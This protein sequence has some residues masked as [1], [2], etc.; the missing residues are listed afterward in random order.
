MRAIPESLYE[1]FK[2]QQGVEPFFVIAIN[3]N[4]EEEIKYSTKEFDDIYGYVSQFS[5]FE[6]VSHAEGL[7]AVSSIAIK[8]ND[9]FGH[10]KEKIDTV[11]LFDKTTVTLYLTVDGV[12]LFDLFEGIIE[13]SAE[14]EGHIWSIDVSSVALDDEVGYTPSIDD[15]AEDHPLRGYYERHLKTEGWPT[16]FND[17]TKYNAVLIADP[18]VSEVQ[19]VTFEQVEGKFITPLDQVDDYDLDTEYHICLVGKEKGPSI[20]HGMGTFRSDKTVEITYP[21]S[22]IWYRDILCQQVTEQ[23]PI[24]P[25]TGQSPR[26]RLRISVGEYSFLD[27]FGVPYITKVTTGPDGDPVTGAWLQLMTARITYS[28]FSGS[29]LISKVLTCNC[30]K[31]EYDICTFDVA[32]LVE[33][34]RNIEIAEAG[35]GLDIIFNIPKETK[36]YIMGDVRRYVV[37]LKTGASTVDIGFEDD[38]RFTTI[39]TDLYEVKTDQLFDHPPCTYVEIPSH[40]IPMWESVKTLLARVTNTLTT[41]QLVIAHLTGKT[42]TDPN[43]KTVNFTYTS[44]EDLKSIIPEIA[45]QSNKGVRRSRAGG[46]DVYELIDLTNL[47]PPVFAFTDHNILRDSISYGYSTEESLKTVFSADF[48]GRD[49]LEDVRTIKYKKNVDKYGEKLLDVDMYI[50]KEYDDADAAFKWWRDKLSRVYY[51]IKFTGFLDAFGL[52][53]WDRVS[54]DFGD[55]RFYDPA[56]GSP[57]NLTHTAT[58]I[59]WRSEGTVKAVRP[60]YYEGLIEF[61]VELDTVTGESPKKA[62]RSIQW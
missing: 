17:V 22:S 5:S 61:R 30:V 41:D 8:F 11:D 54:V 39:P 52:E 4:G 37:D 55:S 62:I 45:W 26:L 25:G 28:Y 53:V 27:E 29:E 7:G 32:T 34:A 15:V 16:V 2:E 31:Q 13:D 6:S 43:P 57:F 3:W 12:E 36:L 42:V 33:G 19:E 40:L 9:M 46:E 14:W 56:K 48:Q 10:F 24:S 50:Y 51:V 38:E 47:G 1:I 20:M 23:I 35:L 44:Q 21:M 49:Y 18:R 59:G 58:P 60:N